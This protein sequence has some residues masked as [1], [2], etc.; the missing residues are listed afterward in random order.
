MKCCLHQSVP[1]TELPNGQPTRL[2]TPHPLPP[3]SLAN[4]ITLLLRHGNL[5]GGKSPRLAGVARRHFAERTPWDSLSDAFVL[6]HDK[7]N[8]PI[9]ASVSLAGWIAD[10]AP[11]SPQIDFDRTYSRTRR[12]AAEQ[13]FDEILDRDEVAGRWQRAYARWG[14]LRKR[15][16]AFETGLDRQIPIFPKCP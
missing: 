13:G 15:V 5:L 4:R 1:Q 8:S 11:C 7:P 10:K 6:A 12:V 16:A 2:P 9:A 3:L 14:K